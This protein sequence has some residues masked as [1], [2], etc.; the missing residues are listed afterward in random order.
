MSGLSSVPI[1]H[2]ISFDD[3]EEEEEKGGSEVLRR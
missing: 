2:D 1:L 3:E